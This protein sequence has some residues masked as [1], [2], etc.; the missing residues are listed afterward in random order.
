MDPPKLHAGCFVAGRVVDLHEPRNPDAVN[1]YVLHERPLDAD[2]QF[3]CL[4]GGAG[5]TA[6]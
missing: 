5:P 3:V 2:S 4:V 6:V 1:C